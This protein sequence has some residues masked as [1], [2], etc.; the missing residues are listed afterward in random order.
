MFLFYNFVDKEFTIFPSEHFNQEIELTNYNFNVYIT[1]T[2]YVK[3][4]D[5]DKFYEMVKYYKD[6]KIKELNFTDMFK[7]KYKIVRT[8]FGPYTLCQFITMK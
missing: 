8:V 5:M 1:D 2:D 4:D 6:I 7:N 3:I